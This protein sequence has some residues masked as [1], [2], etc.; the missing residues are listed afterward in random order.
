VRHKW[1]LNAATRS[2]AAELK[3][4]MNEIEKALAILRDDDGAH[5]DAVNPLEYARQTLYRMDRTEIAET[6]QHANL[7]HAEIADY[8]PTRGG[9][10]RM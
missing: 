7:A 5:W 6:L 1:I 2:S 9:S 10:P 4:A 8:R 3:L